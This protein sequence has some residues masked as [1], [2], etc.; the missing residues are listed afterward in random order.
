MAS[1]TWKQLQEN[2]TIFNAVELKDQLHKWVV[3]A[4]EDKSSQ[5][6]IDV[7]QIEDLDAAGIQLLVTSCQVLYSYDKQLVIA[8]LSKNNLEMLEITGAT[9][10]IKLA[11]Q[12]GNIANE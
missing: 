4:S 7:G 2:L 11:D 8:G 6:V 1:D 5:L 3:E 10:Y 9:N 12:G